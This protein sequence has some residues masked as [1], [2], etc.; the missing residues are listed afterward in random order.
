MTVPLNMQGDLCKVLLRKKD[1][2]KDSK[3]FKKNLANAKIFG[4]GKMLKTL[5]AL[6]SKY[7][8]PAKLA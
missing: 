2:A 7:R 4:N 6:L 1:L 5:S 3:F 8:S